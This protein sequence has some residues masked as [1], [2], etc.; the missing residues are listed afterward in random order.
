M[1]S[2][3][4]KSARRVLDHSLIHSLVR[5]AHSLRCAAVLILT[6]ARSLAPEHIGKKLLIMKWMRRIKTVLTHRGMI[7]ERSRIAISSD[8]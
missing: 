4:M 5:T 1:F 2:M 6:L 8:K 3:I 7:I